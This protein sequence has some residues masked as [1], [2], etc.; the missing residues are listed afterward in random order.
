[1]FALQDNSIEKNWTTITKLK[2]NN[3]LKSLIIKCM[4]EPDFSIKFSNSEN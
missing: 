1:M 4:S 2:W 3:E